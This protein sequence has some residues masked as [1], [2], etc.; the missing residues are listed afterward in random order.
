[1]WW[2]LLAIVVLKLIGLV[3]I[4]VPVGQ[5]RLRAIFLLLQLVFSMLL[6]TLTIWKL[7]FVYGPIM[8]V[9]LVLICLVIARVHLVQQSMQRLFNRYHTWFQGWVAHQSMFDSIADRQ[10]LSDHIGPSSYDTLRDIVDTAQYLTH[11][12]KSLMQS[13]IGVHRRTIA[14]YARPIHDSTTLST[15]DTVGP[16]LLDE[17]HKSP[18]RSYIVLDANNQPV[19]DVSFAQLMKR[20]TKSADILSFANQPVLE[21]PA[22]THLLDGVETMLH[23]QRMI[24]LVAG[25]NGEQIVTLDDLIASLLGKKPT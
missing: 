13:A 24:A 14:Q 7:G 8:A 21:L 16:L 4:V 6:A 22:S 3:A 18:S 15:A 2:I 11:E 25:T 23:E 12:E 9:I 19:G 10:S 20:H 5:R 1:M 17:L